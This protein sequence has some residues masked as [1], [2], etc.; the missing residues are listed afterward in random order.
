MFKK[1]N[2]FKKNQNSR[3][4][5]ITTEQPQAKINNLNIPMQHQIKSHPMQRPIKSHPMQQQIKSHPMQ[6]PIKDPK[7]KFNINQYS[8]PKIKDMAVLLVYFN[9]VKSNR[10]LQ[11]LYTVKSLLDNAEIP[12]FIAELAF[13]T[14][15]FV[16]N[17][18]PHIFQFKTDSYMFYKENLILCAEKLIP[19][20]Y[21]KLCLIDSD[22]LF[23][24]PEWYSIISNK[25]NHVTIIQPFNKAHWLNFD[26]TVQMVKTNVID[27]KNTYTVN[28]SIEHPGFAWA[29]TRNTFNDIGFFDKSIVSSAGD[30]IL[31][32][33][34]SNKVGCGPVILFYE[35]NFKEKIKIN[36]TYEY[37]SCPLNIYHLYH[38]SLS[39][40]QYVSIHDVVGRCLKLNNKCLLDLVYRREDNLLVWNPKYKKDMNIIMLNYFKLRK[41]DE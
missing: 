13:E 29:F 3:S 24:N 15:E 11:N 40:R 35:T 28:Y 39:N 26:F 31:T 36:T 17:K 6:Q 21:D 33:T 12:Y 4:T 9:F 23:D 16:F 14:D 2:H 32:Y 20:T 37:D 30:A 34:V 27:I 25:L 8:S 7:F 19:T 22:I 38:G 5:T 18:Q 41:D 1:I 10:I